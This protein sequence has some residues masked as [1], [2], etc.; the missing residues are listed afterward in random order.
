MEPQAQAGATLDQSLEDCA[1]AGV[2]TVVGTVVDNS[3]VTRVKCFPLEK[4][5]GALSSGVGISHVLP[6]YL[7]NDQFAASGPIGGPTGDLRLMPDVGAMV[8]LALSPSWAWAPY[9]QFT[10]RGAFARLPTCVSRPNGRRGGERGYSL[11]MA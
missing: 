8:P 10:Q 7:M 3:G 11:K 4:I 6:L 1:G 9:D 5:E 2:R